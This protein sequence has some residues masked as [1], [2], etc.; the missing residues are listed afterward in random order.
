MCS[1]EERNKLLKQPILK[2]TDIEKLFDCKSDM[3]YRYI[4]IINEWARQ[5][6]KVPYTCLKK[7][8]RK[9]VRTIDYIEFAGLPRELML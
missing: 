3:S 2:P 4:E 6:G 8:T 9:A 5:N 1:V 7:N